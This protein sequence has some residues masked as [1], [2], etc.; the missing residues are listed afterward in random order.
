MNHQ[1]AQSAPTASRRSSLRAAAKTSDSIVIKVAETE[2]ERLAVYRLRYEIY[3]GER[4]LVQKYADH[5]TRTIVEP[6]DARSCL[7]VA[8]LAGEV[9]GTLRINF[10]RDGGLSDYEE[11]Y[12]MKSVGDAHPARTAMVTKFMI[13]PAHRNGVVI[14]RLCLACYDIGCQHG[15]WFNFID[16]NPPLEKFFGRLGY[17]AYCGRKQHPEYGDVLPMIFHMREESYMGQLAARAVSTSTNSSQHE[18]TTR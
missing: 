9:V 17:R 6:L 1:P 5:A 12:E 8:L 10:A 13:A 4:G 18:N 15:I 11:F 14:L 2:A 16:C 7:L 3:V